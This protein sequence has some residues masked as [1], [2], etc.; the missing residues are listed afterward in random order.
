MKFSILNFSGRP[1]R[2]GASEKPK[3]T[4]FSKLHYNYYITKS[5]VNC[6]TKCKEFTDREV[7][8]K[9]WEENLKEREQ[10]IQDLE[11]KKVTDV[12]VV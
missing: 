10:K 2:L 8:L 5:N 11:A 1:V 9:K 12:E 6:C 7:T 3:I 4:D